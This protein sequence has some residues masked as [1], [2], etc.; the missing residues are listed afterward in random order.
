MTNACAW[1]NVDLSPQKPYGSLGRGAQ[2][3]HLDFHTAPELRGTGSVQ[4]RLFY[5]SSKFEGQSVINLPSFAQLLKSRARG[6]LCRER[7]TTAAG[8]SVFFAIFF[9]LLVVLLLPWIFFL[10]FRSL[11]VTFSIIVLG[12]STSCKPPAKHSVE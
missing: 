1:F 6:G 5:S 8:L 9:L 4:I 11:S 2:D 3:G 10:F 7:L 12:N